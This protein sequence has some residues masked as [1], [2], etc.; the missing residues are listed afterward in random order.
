MT[1]RLNQ[2]ALTFTKSVFI[3]WIFKCVQKSFAMKLFL[4]WQWPL[5][6]IFPTCL[7]HFSIY[8]TLSVFKLNPKSIIL[9]MFSNSFTQT[10]IV[11]NFMRY[12]LIK[13]MQNWRPISVLSALLVLLYWNRIRNR[14]FM[15]FDVL[16][17]LQI[18]K[19]RLMVLS[20]S[21]TVEPM[22]HVPSTTLIP[23]PSIRKRFW[24]SFDKNLIE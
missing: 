10:I 23:Y 18:Q 12:Q 4:F 5:T 1:G 20:V 16:I 21:L 11:L 7:P 3:N 17:Q 6:P 15:K 19:S 8:F 2:T 9:T 24:A 22:Y 13:N 14:G